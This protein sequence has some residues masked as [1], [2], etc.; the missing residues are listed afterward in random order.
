V[1][2]FVVTAVEFSIL[3][4]SFKNVEGVC[5]KNLANGMGGKMRRKGGGVKVKNITS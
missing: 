1:T 5:E 4:K 3:S 2:K